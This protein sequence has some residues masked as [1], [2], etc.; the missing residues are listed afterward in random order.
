MNL[1]LYLETH[2]QEGLDFKFWP[3]MIM[4]PGVGLG[5]PLNIEDSW[6]HPRGTFPDNTQDSKFRYSWVP[7]LNA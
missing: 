7:N 3:A 6:A 1:K 5:N 2:H 4:E